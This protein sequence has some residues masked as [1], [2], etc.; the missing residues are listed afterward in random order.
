MTHPLQHLFDN[1]ARWAAG[2]TTDDPHYFQR[3]STQQKPD[4]L[5]IGC[6]D[7]RVPAN[8]I[9]GLDPGEV[10]VHRNVA[11]VVVHTDMNCLSV[12]QYAVDILKVKHIIVCGHYGCGGVLAAMENTQH[13]LIDNWLRHIKDVYRK[14]QEEINAIGD[15][16]ER[17][18]RVCEINILEQMANICYTTI[19]QNAWQR[20]Q[21]LA[22]HGWVYGL[23]DGLVKDL[24]VIIDKP[25]QL[26][27]AYRMTNS[28]TED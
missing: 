23:T 25:E 2:E 21:A 13:G 19:V 6:A 28:V 24:G 22:V 16:A 1:N 20:G 11:N 27:T 26:P 10:F 18:A 9:I 5:W 12:V 8:E 3:L 14:H 17:Q 15:L 4:Y 7:S